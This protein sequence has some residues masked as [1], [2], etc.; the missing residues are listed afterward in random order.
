MLGTRRE[1]RDSE[2]RLQDPV[3]TLSYRLGMEN[4]AE[5]EYLIEMQPFS[6]LNTTELK[7]PQ[8][9]SPGQ[10]IPDADRSKAML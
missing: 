8:T 9:M 4:F 2:F 1:G 6:V 7:K 10:I 5:Y 3:P